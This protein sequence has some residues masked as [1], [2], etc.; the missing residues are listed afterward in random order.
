MAATRDL[1]PFLNE[2]LSSTLAPLFS[3]NRSSKKPEKY[4][5]NDFLGIE[6]ILHQ[7]RS[8][9][10]K[11]DE[12]VNKL[13][14]T[15]ALSKVNIESNLMQIRHSTTALPRSTTLR[16]RYNTNVQAYEQNDHQ[17]DSK[18]LKVQFVLDCDLKDSLNTNLNLNK[19][20]IPH[21]QTMQ[22]I[23]SVPGNENAYNQRIPARKQ[24]I[25][26]YQTTRRPYY[27]TTKP[28]KRVIVKTVTTP[29]AKV[30]NVYIDPPAVAAISNAFENVYNYFEDALTT[31]VVQ[32]IPRKKERV[33][34]RKKN[35]VHGQERNPIRKRS[36]VNHLAITDRPEY[37]YT[38][39]HSN[40]PNQKLTTQIHVTSEYVGTEPPAGIKQNENI[41]DELESAEYDGDL[42][43][44]ESDE[45]YSDEGE[46]DYDYDF[47]FGEL[48]GDDEVRF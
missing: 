4:K 19:P 8:D 31:N 48:G 40:G 14:K 23:P 34:E 27:P 15:G 46:G 1:N 7:N 38:K 2:T 18:E 25:S 3:F 17:K 6:K 13:N 11:L 41:S 21:S 16:S 37:R 24:V 20:V 22:Y 42:D 29:K 30:K 33:I 12:L 39:A 32:K 28:T 10:E 47:P 43:D 45:E 35:R 36:T 26:H 9:V 44:S 5:I